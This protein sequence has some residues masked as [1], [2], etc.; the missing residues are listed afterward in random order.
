M[1]TAFLA[2]WRGVDSRGPSSAYILSKGA[3]A[4]TTTPDLFLSFGD[5]PETEAAI[6]ALDCTSFAH[7]TDPDA[8]ALAAYNAVKDLGGGIPNPMFHVFR[9]GEGM[10]STFHAYYSDALMEGGLIRG[11]SWEDGPGD[12]VI[13]TDDRLGKF[14]AAM[15]ELL[16]HLKGTSR[17]IVGAYC[18]ADPDATPNLVGLY[19]AGPGRDMGLERKGQGVWVEGWGNWAYLG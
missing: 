8:R 17:T 7:L 18:L 4:S 2:A 3:H 1:A 14:K 19:R 15:S 6:R 16:P 5:D 11:V 12:C 10:G 9:I 13:G